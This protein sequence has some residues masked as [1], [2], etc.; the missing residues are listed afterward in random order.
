MLRIARVA[1]L[2]AV[3][4][5][6][7]VHAQSPYSTVYVFGDSI[8][9]RGRIP[10]LILQQNPNFPPSELFPK[11]PYFDARF[12]NGPTYAELLPGLIGAAVNPGLNFA[13]GGAFTNTQNLANDFLPGGLTLPGIRTEIDSFTG[14]GGRFDPSA[15]VVHFGGAND[16]FAFLNPLLPPPAIG[17]VPGAVAAVTGNIQSNIQALAGAGAKTILVPNIPDLAS[18]PGY[19]GTPFAGVAGALSAQHAAALNA[20]LGGLAKQ[21]NVNIYV[22][23]FATGF[24]TALANPGLFGFT[25]VTDA[26]VKSLSEKQPPY[27]TPGPPCSNPD[28]YLFWDDVHPTAAAHRLLAQYAADTLLAPLSIAAQAA[29]SL[30]NGD[31]FLRRM[32][33]AVLATGV[34]GLSSPILKGT[35]G[36]GNVFLNIQRSFGDGSQATNALGFDYGVT[37]VSGGAIVRPSN[38]VALGLIGGFDDGTATLD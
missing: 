5:S 19:R 11:P 13:V 33:E 28:Q 22:V 18:T 9:D 12:S 29:F 10:E 21:L 3:I 7:A 16:Y 36:G 14:S 6:T 32:Q 25:N 31:N 2:V 35:L 37:Q 26:C 20:Q 24:Q 4:A 34:P 8:S 1:A 30:T 17:Q 15:V 38:N 23:D 27:I